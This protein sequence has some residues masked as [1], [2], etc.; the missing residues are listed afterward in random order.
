VDVPGKE[1]RVGAHRGGGAMVGWWRDIG[2][3][4]VD[5]GGRSDDDWR[6]SEVH[7]LL[8]ESERE[9]R[10]E[11]KWEKWG[12]GSAV[13]A[14]TS[15]RGWR[16]WRGQIPDEGQ[17]SNGGGGRASNKG[18]RGRRWLAS[19]AIG[20]C[21]KKL[22]DGGRRQLGFR[23]SRERARGGS[24]VE[25]GAGSELQPRGAGRLGRAV[26]PMAGPES[27]GAGSSSTGQGSGV[28]VAGAWY[29]ENGRWAGPRK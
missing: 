11:T 16:R 28:S 6:H 19:G 9:M 15:E 23:L 17:C 18:W 21:R 14:L 12:G 8:H 5:G 2:A 25:G 20:S 10:P 24:G 29:G 22:M 13:A 27:S 1:T 26:W 4:K 3:A 7:L